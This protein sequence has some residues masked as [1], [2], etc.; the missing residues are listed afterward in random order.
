MSSTLAVVHEP[1]RFVARLDGMEAFLAYE[2][3]GDLLDAQHTYTPPALRGRGV[4][5]ALTRAAVDHAAAH[6]LR[7]VPT[8]SYVRAY[9]DRHPELHALRAPG[10]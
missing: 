9:F 7:I 4:A 10:H 6:G 8:C 5:E 1:G 2:Q 3:R